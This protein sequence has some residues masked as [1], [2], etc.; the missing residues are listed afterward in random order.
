MLLHVGYEVFLLALKEFLSNAWEELILV[1][2]VLQLHLE[3]QTS[4]VDVG[5]SEQ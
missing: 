5:S 2:E 3:I 4:S 1:V